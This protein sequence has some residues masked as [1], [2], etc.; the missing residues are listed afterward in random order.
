M[1]YS[2]ADGIRCCLLLSLRSS[3]RSR[4]GGPSGWQNQLTYAR[5]HQINRTRLSDKQG[6]KF[7][8]DCRLGHWILL[9]GAA[10]SVTG[11][12]RRQSNEDTG[13]IGCQS[14]QQPPTFDCDL[15]TPHSNP[16]KP[17]TKLDPQLNDDAISD[18]IA[19]D[20]NY[21]DDDDIDRYGSF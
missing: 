17:L 14:H 5:K 16:T 10:V 6:R 8:G 9:Q 20:D 12:I 7:V 11:E 15:W 4:Y 1:H 3:S 13:Q 19:D 18:A 21:D 2:V